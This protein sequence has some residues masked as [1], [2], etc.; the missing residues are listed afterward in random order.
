MLIRSVVII[1][2]LMPTKLRLAK[3]FK[4]T[5]NAV[6]I[7]DEELPFHIAAEGPR[8]EPLDVNMTILWLPVLVDMPCPQLGAPDDASPATVSNPVVNG[9]E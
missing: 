1:G 9:D 6:L 4:L 2:V 5:R 7:D 3:S 8:I